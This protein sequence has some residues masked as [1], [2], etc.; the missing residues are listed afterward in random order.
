MGRTWPIKA[1]VTI[2]LTVAAGTPTPAAGDKNEAASL[3][4][5][6]RQPLSQRV[7]AYE[8]DARLDVAKRTITASEQLI[9]HNLTGQPQQTFPFHLY[10]NAFQPQ[11]TFMTE[12]R[13]YN[14]EYGWRPEQYGAIRVTRLEVVGVGDL[15]SQMEF[16]HPDDSNAEDRTVFQVRLPRPVAPGADVRF[17]VSFEDQL[18]K[19]VA[20]TGYLRDFFMVAQW[21]PKVG[22]WWK[23]AW[24][25][26]QFHRT[27]EFFADFGTFDVKITLPQNEIVGAGGDLVATANH[28]DGTKSLTF[29]SEDVHDFSWTASPSFTDVEESWT[30]SAGI[31]KIHLLMSPGNMRS[32]PRYLKALKGTLGL[33][34]KWIGPY[35]YD[36]ITVV[37]PPH[38]GLN[39]GGMEYP[40]L[41][42]A[43]TTWNMPKGSLFPEVVVEHEFGHQYWYGMVAT[44][45]FEEA[46]LDEGINSYVEVKVMDEL[47][48]KDT[49]VSRF[50]FATMGE[51]AYQRDNYIPMPDTDPMTRHA[52]Q[53]YNGS[54]YGG[55][56]YAKTATVLLTL[57]KLIGEETMRTALHTYFLR[58][59]FTHP[60][61]E[62]FLKTIEEVSGRDLH[63]YFDQAV[64]GT[65]IL[66]YEILDAHSEPL[67]WYEKKPQEAKAGETLYRTYVT[68]HRKGDFVF[69][70]D[71]EVRF[72]DS[73]SVIEHWDGRDRWVRYTYIRK[74]KL[75]SAQVDPQHQVWLDRDFFNNSYVAKADRRATFKLANLWLFLNEWLAQSLTW[76]F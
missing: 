31:V 50:P 9:Y 62:D 47:Y 57:E 66:D 54:A 22:V 3:A 60:T 26:H 14:P 1:F 53:F 20:R 27:T 13:L 39:A 15:T 7:V 61:G 23:G 32:A 49:S 34:D 33:Y 10:L 55:I 65:A 17:E 18:P 52:W 38:G 67:K 41:I 19:V 21:F 46:W 75:V 71:V 64:S 4:A 42:T 6:N 12:T 59:R 72:G 8:I 63:W 16:I 11:S 28:T 76:L 25:C 48:G 37:D 69:P 73:T 44:N 51:D 24:N 5:E 29:H 40:T 36:R 68:V 58:Y 70:V 35:P 56:T 74:T 2:G 43:G 45:E 30:G